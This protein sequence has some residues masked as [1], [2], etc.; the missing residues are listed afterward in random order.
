M[1]T[2]HFFRMM[3]CAILSSC[4]LESVEVAPSV[5]PS[6]DGGDPTYSGTLKFQFN[7]VCCI[8]GKRKERLEAMDTQLA[9]EYSKLIEGNPT[10]QD[11]A[12]YNRKRELFKATVETYLTSW[13]PAMKSPTDGT[14]PLTVKVVSPKPIE[15]KPAAGEIAEIKPNQ[16]V[17]AISADTLSVVYGAAE[18]RSVAGE[19]RSLIQR[20]EIPTAEVQSKADAVL[21]LLEQDLGQSR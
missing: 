7:N 2:L 8:K 13:C 21:L 18:G 10:D 17:T 1:K 12:T 20:K 11:I 16:P 3:F 15:P 19:K 9:G 4:C 14:T 6:K 5:T